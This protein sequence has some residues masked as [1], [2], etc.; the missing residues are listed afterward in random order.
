MRVPSST[1][2]RR[3]LLGSVAATAL[4]GCLG[5]RRTPALD[6]DDWPLLGG[7]PG[8]TGYAPEA[9]PPR[10]TPGVAWE[11]TPDPATPRSPIVADGT[12]YYQTSDELFV[13]DPRTGDGRQVDT[14]GAF[15]GTGA[16]AFVPTEPYS[17]GAYL[18]PYGREIA[19]Y[20]ADPETWPGSIPDDGRRRMRWSSLGDG[21]AVD[22][23]PVDRMGMLTTHPIPVD[24]RI[25]FRTGVRE[26][27]VTVVDADD[28]S[29]VWEAPVGRG[30]GE[31][32]RGVL[33]GAVTA[34]DTDRGVVVCLVPTADGGGVTGRRLTDG[35]HEWHWRH[36]AVPDTLAVDD[37]LAVVAAADAADE[38]STLVGLS[39]R[40]GTPRWTTPVAAAERFGVALDG[41]RCYLLGS[42]AADGDGAV[43][44]TAVDREDG[45]VA[46]ER[47]VGVASTL[48][49]G[50]PTQHPT[51]GGDVLL[52]PGG[53]ALHAFD[54]AT[55]EHLWRFARTVGTSGGSRSARRP[56][57]PVVPVG[58]RLVVAM[59]LALYGLEA[60]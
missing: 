23:H 50:R 19:A 49:F 48:G 53:E 3:H 27:R 21:V 51:V 59:T 37:G 43:S 28:G 9:T 57:T 8:R 47:E 25:V 55:G 2:T 60:K 5:T 1:L 22:D 4:G 18:V 32:I 36:D 20:P 44:V 52:V 7:D 30:V 17:D 14:F 15:E 33:R 42:T 54:R 24:G 31:S 39:T 13:L 6:A 26:D 11:K 35:R 10:S 40:D 16:P 34:V 38:G 45:T 56:T 58:D 12:L 41:T 46:W 29:P